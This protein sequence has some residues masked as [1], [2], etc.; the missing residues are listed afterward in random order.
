MS[1]LF[2][3]RTPMPEKTLL[4]LGPVPAPT[5]EIQLLY[6]HVQTR[7]RCYDHRQT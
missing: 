3:P 6:D 4:L 7:V 5:D 1:L 2:L